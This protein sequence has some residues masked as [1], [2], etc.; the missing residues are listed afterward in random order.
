ML[1]YACNRA[2]NR[3]FPWLGFRSLTDCVSFPHL[4]FSSR[5]EPFFSFH[6]WLLVL[7]VL[8][9]KEKEKNTHGSLEIIVG[10]GEFFLSLH[11]IIGNNRLIQASF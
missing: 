10:F 6:T 7:I 2:S 3:S 4:G 11:T 5:S 8:E 9:K 1:C